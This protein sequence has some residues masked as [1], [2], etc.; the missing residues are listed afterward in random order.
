MIAI[1]KK[2][3]RLLFQNVIGWLFLGVTLAL[4]GLYFFIYNIQYGYPT[5][6]YSLSGVRFIL[7]ITVPL[8]TMRSFSEERK[9]KTDQL[10]FTSP[11]STGKIV[12][13]KYLSLATVFL[14]SVA[15]VC[16]APLFLRIFGDVA[17][18]ESYTA[19]FGYAIYGLTMIAIGVFVSACTESVAIAA[20]VSVVLL[21]IGYMMTNITSVISEDGNVLTTILNCYDLTGAL[22]DF[23]AGNFAVGGT[24]YYISVTVLCLIL[25]TQVLLK[26]RFTINKAKLGTTFY[27][28]GTIILSFVLVI[29][30]NFGVTKLPENMQYLDVT[31][32]KLYSLTDTTKDFLKT[33]DKDVTISVY[34]KKSTADEMLKKTL[35]QYKSENRHITVEYVDPSKNPYYGDGNLTENS[36]IVSAGDRSRTISYDDLYE[37]EMD[38]YT[39]SETVTGYD[40]EGQITS[41]IAYVLSDSVISVVE[42]TGHGETAL[43]GQYVSAFSK[44][45][46][47]LSELNLLDADEI[48]KDTA[49]VIINGAANDFSADD[50]EKMKTYLEN[51]GK[52]FISLNVLAGDM[53]NFD[54][55]LESCGV[56]VREGLVKEN[57]AGYY[58]NTNFYLLPEVEA[59]DV[60]ENLTSYVFM[61]DAVAISLVEDEDKFYDVTL[62]T[63]SEDAVTVALEESE[64]TEGRIAASDT[65]LEKG[66]FD[67][68]VS[69]G[70]G[71]ETPDIY[72]FGSFEMFTDAADQLVAG[73][74]R[75][76]FK[77]VVQSLAA[78]NENADEAPTVSVDVKSY[79]NDYITF[80]S[81]AAFWYG[82]IW[83]IFLPVVLIIVGVVIFIYR[84]AKR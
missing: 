37:T 59:T 16:I 30:V 71:T 9:H 2:E 4:F 34:A 53:P 40:G 72:V 24:I 62:L 80:S 50:C 44:A 55:L 63:T 18:P 73:T 13:A 39:Y 49:L 76:L 22:D 8:L 29:A 27:S 52:L 25:T 81:S 67:L 11:V 79:S 28:L 41:A 58:Y 83:G 75:A 23:L 65:E 19:I 68:G 38:Y 84:R 12:L 51:G 74:N 21:F 56:T 78:G 6:A 17:F 45:N 43:S 20:I 69:V 10:L 57:D 42:L 15:V 47:E 82:L 66:P 77:N 54:N 26:R 64:E 33:V 3:I 14:I 31:E 35:S 7:I 60:T 48:P 70:I 36:V 46:M 5:I 1:Y 32:K 61:P